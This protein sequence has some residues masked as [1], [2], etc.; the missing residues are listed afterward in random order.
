[1]ENRQLSM[2]ICYV[3]K[4]SDKSGAMLLV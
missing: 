3:I 4:L 1:M 2:Q